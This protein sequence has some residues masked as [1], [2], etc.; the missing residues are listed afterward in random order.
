MQQRQAGR[1]QAEDALARR[2]HPHR[3]VAAGAMQRLAALVP[4]ARLHLIRLHGVLAPNAKL[5]AQLVPAGPHEATGGSELTAPE[6]VCAHTRPVRMSWA[7]LLKRVFEI[8][9]GISGTA[10]IAPAS[11]R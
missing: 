9:L 2:H 11:S 8:D 4:R 6:P 3:D 7:R 1:A 5:R 10:R